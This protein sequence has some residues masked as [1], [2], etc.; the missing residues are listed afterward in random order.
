MTRRINH[1]KGKKEKGD[2]PSGFSRQC[3]RVPDTN[4]STT[5]V[6]RVRA[7][8]LSIE[9]KPR[10]FFF[11]PHGCQERCWPW[12]HH[13][14]RGNATEEER[15]KRTTKKKSGGRERERESWEPALR[16]ENETKVRAFAGRFLKIK[17]RPRRSRATLLSG[18]RGRKEK[19]EE[20]EE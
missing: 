16:R 17:W 14:R 8:V 1:P 2:Q 11:Q 4:T 9:E 3:T 19:G 18:R 5:T 7:S 10:L 20:G 13:T 12:R 15:K 6:P